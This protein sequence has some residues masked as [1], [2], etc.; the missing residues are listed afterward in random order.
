MSSAEIHSL[1]LEEV[2]N[3]TQSKMQFNLQSLKDITAK[4]QSGQSNLENLREIAIEMQSLHNMIE[5]LNQVNIK[6]ATEQREITTKLQ[7][8]SANKT[9]VISGVATKQAPILISTKSGRTSYEFKPE[10]A[11]ETKTL[12]ETE[13]LPIFGI[14]NE[15]LLKAYRIPRPKYVSTKKPPKLVVKFDKQETV[16]QIIGNLSKLKNWPK[17]AKWHFE[18]DVPQNLREKRK[19]GNSISYMY[20]KQNQ[21]AKVKVTFFNNNLKVAVKQSQY[22]D[23]CILSNEEMKY[24]TPFCMKVNETPDILSNLHIP[25][26][27]EKTWSGLIVQYDSSQQNLDF[28]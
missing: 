25:V 22:T 17:A 6:I 5:K 1:S 24:Y 21:Q 16:S 10:S 8:Q 26:E 11:K 19:L 7:W 2:L 9:I 3:Y 18:K 20:R 28:V 13:I 27:K 15:A 23:W 12:V 14:K 4:P